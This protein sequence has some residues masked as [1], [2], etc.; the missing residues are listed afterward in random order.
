MDRDIV[1]RDVTTPGDLFRLQEHLRE[2]YRLLDRR[3]IEV[4]RAASV[5]FD[6]DEGDVFYCELDGNITGITLKNPYQGRTVTLI[7][8]QDGT[9]SRT[10]SGFDSTVMLAG[11][12]FSVTSNANR[13]TTITLAY[14]N[15]NSKWVEISRTSDVY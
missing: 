5:T 6:T 11:D 1:F 13:Y 2:L 4:T 3:Y 12:A 10:V 7:F 14:E 8:K 9:G 15:K